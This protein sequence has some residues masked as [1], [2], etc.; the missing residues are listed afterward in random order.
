MKSSP[1]SLNLKHLGGL[2]L[3]GVAFSFLLGCSKD[4]LG[5]VAVAGTVTLQDRKGCGKNTRLFV[6]T[7]I[8]WHEIDRVLVHVVHQ[9]DTEM[10]QARLRVTHGSGWI[11]L[12]RTEVSL[13]I[14]E[15]FSHGPRLCHVDQ[16]RINGAITMGMVLTHGITYNTG[17]LE[18]GFV[19]A[20]AQVVVH[21]IE[22]A[23]LGRFEAIACIGQGTRNDDGHRVV[24]EGLR[25]LVGHIDRGNTIV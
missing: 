4:E 7:I 16:G 12:N 20:E 6:R 17:T 15:D 11:A 2:V 14:D 5:R 1:N 24:Q 3:V 8:V 19:R 18:V 22:K 10:G 25:H 23:T 21:R 9:R 13:A